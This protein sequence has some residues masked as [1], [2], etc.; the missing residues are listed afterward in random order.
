MKIENMSDKN[1][2]LGF[3]AVGDHIILRCEAAREG[4]EVKSSMGIIVEAKKTQAEI[5]LSATVVSVG[6]RCPSEYKEMVGCE[7]A[8]PASGTFGKFWDPR[9]VRKEISPDSK[10]DIIYITTPWAAIRAVY[11]HKDKV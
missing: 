10:K 5:P 6:N 1:K 3:F 8:I 9:V 7:V 4:E 2:S 11:D